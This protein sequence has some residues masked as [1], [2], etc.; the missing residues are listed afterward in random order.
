MS[1][2]SADTRNGDG[3]L[4]EIENLS[5]AF[6]GLVAVDSYSLRL[7]AGEILGII[8]PNGAGK[9]TVF[10]L[11]S[12]TLAP[13]SGT[14][15]FKKEN[16]TGRPPYHIARRG[17]ARTFQN[18]RLFRALSV[19]D[20]IKVGVQM[21]RRTHLG[22]TLLSLPAFRRD[23][24]HLADEALQL[25]ELFGLAEYRDKPA[26]SLSFGHQRRLEIA[27]AL[28]TRPELLLLD[29]PAAGMNPHEKEDLVALI[30]RVQHEFGLTI[31]LI[32]HDMRVIMGICNR[33]QALNYGRIIAEGTPEEIQNNPDVIE[34]YLGHSRGGMQREERPQA[35]RRGAI[36]GNTGAPRPAEGIFPDEGVANAA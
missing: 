31:M 23:E 16:I 10:N 6:K 20:N 15:C 11:I 29:E 22:E 24:K 21:H 17:I 5:K 2:T 13:T 12:G 36:Q 18:I 3:C 30:G 19:L 25:L 26:Q 9:T 32:E 4:L 28:A 34:A 27:S 7:C 8:G 1:M 33:I 14:V 35:D